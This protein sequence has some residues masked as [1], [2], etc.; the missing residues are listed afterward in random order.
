MIPTFLLT[1]ATWSAPAGTSPAL[2]EAHAAYLESDDAGFVE[3]VVTAFK[4]P[5]LT[6]LEAQNLTSLLGAA[7]A[8]RR[9]VL[10]SE[11]RLP[12]GLAEL[13]LVQ[14]R[15]ETRDRMDYVT[16]FTGKYD[17]PGKIEKLRLIRWPNEVILDKASAAFEF[18]EN[19]DGFYLKRRNQVPDAE[20]LYFVE[21]TMADGGTA[22]AWVPVVDWASDKTPV[23]DA[24]RAYQSLGANPEVQWLPFSTGD[25][26]YEGRRFSVQ[27]ILNDAPDYD[28]VTRWTLYG[29]DG[30]ETH[31]TVGKD[32]RGDGVTGLTPGRYLLNVTY[33][34][35]RRVG[36]LQIVK[37]SAT[38][39]PFYAR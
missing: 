39:V 4:D 8:D 28:W 33:S 17:G 36:D 31:T 20:G 24:P 26:G 9:G 6:P 34:E 23:L 5:N 32:P 2:V 25:R 37:Q 38:R 18:E 27:A 19:P 1:L 13:R 35:W 29:K 3:S 16:E 10:P 22:S 12:H 14:R 21:V 15:A 7:F 11:F 30:D